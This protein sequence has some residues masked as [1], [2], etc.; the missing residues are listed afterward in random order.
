MSTLKILSDTHCMVRCDFQE[1]GDIKLQLKKGCYILE[2]LVEDIVIC[3]MDYTIETND[4][5]PLLRLNIKEQAKKKIMEQFAYVFSEDGRS[6]M[7]CNKYF[8]GVFIM[9]EGIER[10]AGYAFSDCDF[11]SVIIP[12]NV[13]IIE[14]YAFINCHGLTSVTIPNSVTSIGKGAFFN[15]I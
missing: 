10:I 9:P 8:K 12:N 1:V 4:E 15:C 6:L 13:K 14:D 3:S 11:S 2:F 5:E 7:G